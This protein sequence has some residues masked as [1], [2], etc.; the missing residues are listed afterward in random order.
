MT[1]ETA[2]SMKSMTVNLV[3][4]CPNMVSQHSF[5]KDSRSVSFN[6]PRSSSTMGILGSGSRQDLKVVVSPKEMVVMSASK[7]VSVVNS[8]GMVVI[9]SVDF[10]GFFV[11]PFGFVEGGLT[12][13]AQVSVAS[14]S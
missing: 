6:R 8:V 1:V 5:L 2:V 10:E 11:V 4:S 7:L 14:V 3:N 9:L 13:V 12:E